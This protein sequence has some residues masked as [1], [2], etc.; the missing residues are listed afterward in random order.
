MGGDEG[1]R[2]GGEGGR[3][4]RRLPARIAPSRTVARRPE[5]A[6]IFRIRIAKTPGARGTTLDERGTTG[7]ESEEH[8]T[9][10]EQL[11]THSR[12]SGASCNDP[13]PNHGSFQ[14]LATAFGKSQRLEVRSCRLQA[15]WQRLLGN[16]NDPRSDHVGFKSYR[17]GLREIGTTRGPITA[18]PAGSQ[19]PTGNRNDPRP[20]RDDPKGLRVG[21]GGA[22]SYISRPT[23]R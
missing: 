16:R 11:D 21:P 12:R 19:R 10:S 1:R 7:S 5:L 13:R 22:P 9:G 23:A 15:V 8:G 17:N 18:A 20:H 4:A 14:K 6:T 3:G 2:E